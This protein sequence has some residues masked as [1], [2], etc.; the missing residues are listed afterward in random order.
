MTRDCESYR[1]DCEAIDDPGDEFKNK[2][3]KNGIGV[4]EETCRDMVEAFGEFARNKDTQKSNSI[5]I[6][7]NPSP[8]SSLLVTFLWFGLL[9]RLHR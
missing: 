1:N 5:T 4:K 3:G 7:S 8:S 2:I 6:K 9:L